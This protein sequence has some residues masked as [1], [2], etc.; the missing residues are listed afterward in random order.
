[1]VATTG[2]DRGIGRTLF[3][4]AA[5]YASARAAGYY[6]FIQTFS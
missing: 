3:H 2:L 5:W 6:R 1:M 4:A